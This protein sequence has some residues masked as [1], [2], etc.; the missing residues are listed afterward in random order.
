MSES[1]FLLFSG[2]EIITLYCSQQETLINLTTISGI[3]CKLMARDVHIQLLDLDPHR[4]PV[5]GGY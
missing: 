1:I 2:L 5:I 4:F 3:I